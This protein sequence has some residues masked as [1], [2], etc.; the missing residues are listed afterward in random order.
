MK[1]LTTTILVLALLG[2]GRFLPAQGTALESWK[3]RD[4]YEYGTDLLRKGRLFK[5][6][7][8]ALEIAANRDPTDVDYQRALGCALASRFASVALAS[9]HADRYENE[10]KGYEIRRER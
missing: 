4:L 9:L 1:G 5:R 2:P 7:I 6:S 3:T 8:A 10:L